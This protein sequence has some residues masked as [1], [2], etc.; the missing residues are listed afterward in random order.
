MRTLFYFFFAEM[1]N[2]F[3]LRSPSMSKEYLKMALELLV[4][5]SMSI[6]VNKISS[7]SPAPRFAKA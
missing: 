4:S 5:T 6:R 3:V 2:N 7:Y 1:D